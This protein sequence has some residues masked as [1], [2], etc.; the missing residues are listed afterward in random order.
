[1]SSRLL[2]ILGA[3]AS[4][5]CASQEVE[6]RVDSRPPLVTE[7]FAPRFAQIL[8]RYPLAE[9]AA[10]GIRTAVANGSLAVESVLRER[11]RDSPHEHE[12]RQYWSIPLYLQDLFFEIGSGGRHGYAS[13]PDSY[14][15]LLN[16]ALRVE[17]TTFVTLNYD[18]LFD[19]RF[20]M[21]VDGGL[22]TIDSYLAADQ[23]RALIKLHGSINWARKVLNPP[24]RTASDDPL[25][26]AT[27]AGLGDSIELSDLIIFR[28]QERLDY[29]RQEPVHLRQM[30]QP[31]ELFYPAL[32]VPLGQVDDEVVCPPAHTDY[33][34]ETTGDPDLLD[35][36]VI[37]YSG[38]DQGVLELLSW[39][40]RP[41]KSLTVVSDNQEN[42]M[43]AG[44]NI[45]AKVSVA[46]G[47]NE[48]AFV[49]GFAEFARDGSLD[50]YIQQISR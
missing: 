36:L 17:Q 40:G 22:Q 28:P 44:A 50:R 20:F 29:A 35:V 33:L 47:G 21:H 24:E 41:I 38:L 48:A 30:G 15:R 43:R 9:Q 18:D 42:A 23:P 4:F 7:L 14:D 5:D 37:G 8:N 39:G 11:L 3:G 25:L 13:H 19:R 6:T 26:A 16:A 45:R 1:V 31:S 2:I 27:L 34:R 49:E 12:R 10:A 46:P 32:S